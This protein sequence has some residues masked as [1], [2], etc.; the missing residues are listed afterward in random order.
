MVVLLT[1][2]F[3]FLAVLSQP[4]FQISIPQHPTQ[5]QDVIFSRWGEYFADVDFSAEYFS[6]LM[7]FLCVCMGAQPVAHHCGILIL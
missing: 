2:R 4:S 6:D 1:Y 3:I 7:I 5:L